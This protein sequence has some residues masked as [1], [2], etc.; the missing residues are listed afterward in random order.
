MI[1]GAGDRGGDNQRQ[2]QP[3]VKQKETLHSP[4]I[5]I[6]KRLRRKPSNSP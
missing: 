2:N 3:D 6:S 1:S 5:L 4:I